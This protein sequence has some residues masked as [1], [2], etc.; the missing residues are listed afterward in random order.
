MDYKFK[1]GDRVRV[2]TI[3]N[4]DYYCKALYKIGDVGTIVY[5]DR[6]YCVRFDKSKADSEDP[7]WYALEHWLEFE[8][9]NQVMVFE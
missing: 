3:D 2:T 4:Q 8:T 7:E 6:H 9:D 1:V 5:C